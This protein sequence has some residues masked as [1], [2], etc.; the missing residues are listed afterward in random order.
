MQTKTPTGI[1]SPRSH[2]LK[3][4]VPHEGD[5]V[6]VGEFVICATG[7]MYGLGYLD[8]PDM[9]YVPL[10][11]VPPS[12]FG[13]DSTVIEAILPDFG[14]VLDNWQEFLEETIIPEL[15]AGQKLLAFCAGSH[16]RTG[17]FL[18]SLIALLETPE[19]TPD[20]IAAVRQRHC[21]EAVET[22]AQA[23]AVFALRGQPV[24][25]YYR[26]RLL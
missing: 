6:Q 19:V 10:T 24:P 21:E 23:R 15:Q 18:A 25:A 20:P 26:K 3:P 12:T 11:V 2:P 13:H 1:G 7:T 4:H 5:A 22:V 8:D 16:G 17:V 9:V 14:G